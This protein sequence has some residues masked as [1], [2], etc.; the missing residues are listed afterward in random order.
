[1]DSQLTGLHDLLTS[2]L[3]MGHLKALIYLEPISDIDVE[4]EQ[5]ENACQEIRVKPGILEACAS[6]R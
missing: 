6:L 5:V 2:V 3:W 4:Q 1:M